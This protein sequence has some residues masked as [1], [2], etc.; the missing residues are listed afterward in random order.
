MLDTELSDD[1]DIQRQLR[2]QYCVAKKL[3]ASFPRCSNA[4]K[5]VLFRSFCTPCMHHS[6]GVISRSHACR[7]CVWPIILYAELFTTCP[8]E[9]VS[10]HQVQCN[11]PTFEALLR[12]NVFVNECLAQ[13]RTHR[14]FNFADDKT[15][16]SHKN[17]PLN[18]KHICYD[19]STKNYQNYRCL[20]FINSTAYEARQMQLS[21]CR[22]VAR[23]TCIM[24]TLSARWISVSLASFFRSEATERSRCSRCREY[25]FWIS[26][27]T[28]A[29]SAC[30]V[31]S[32]KPFY[33]VQ[34]V[35]TLNTAGSCW[36][37]KRKNW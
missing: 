3:R 4:V 20:D 30:S 19:T 2:Y 21:Y 7:D 24:R 22:Q 34:R 28:P 36:V 32:K 9:P 8:G 11:I 1:K 14:Y 25:S 26:T 37:K 16:P 17:A 12:E 18:T 15:N 13:I 6:Y 27:S 29:D 31:R 10:S 33:K 23:L 5:N 35:V